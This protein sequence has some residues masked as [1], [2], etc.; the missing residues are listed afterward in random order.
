MLGL[1]RISERGS[2]TRS[3]VVYGGNGTKY[4]VVSA[5]VNVQITLRVCMVPRSIPD[6]GK[7]KISNWYN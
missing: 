4:L 3:N 2:K 5:A 1:M 6:R 7:P